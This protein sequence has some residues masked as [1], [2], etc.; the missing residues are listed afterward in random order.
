[1]TSVNEK[2]VDVLT[3]ALEPHKEILSEWNTDEI[4]MLFMGFGN[5]SIYPTNVNDYN[6]D[7]DIGGT[8]AEN[9][10]AIIDALNNIGIDLSESNWDSSDLYWLIHSYSG[11]VRIDLINALNVVGY[12]CYKWFDAEEED[13]EP[14]MVEG[15]AAEPS[16]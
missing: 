9:S 15:W 8:F 16:L 11:E 6:N 1:M 13:I 10:V 3:N 2:L 4:G 12:D 5:I 7:E 14:I